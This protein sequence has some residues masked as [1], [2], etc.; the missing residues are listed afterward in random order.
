[1]REELVRT[2]LMTGATGFL[3]NFVLRDLLQRG[4]RVVAILRAPLADRRERLLGLLQE[5]GL[6]ARRCMENGQL[7]LIEGGLPDSLPEP[8]WGR[9][10]DILH[11]A[12]SLELFT[13]GDPQGDPYRTNVEGAMAMLQW[14]DRHE[15]K[16]VLAVSTAYTCGW[17]DGVIPEAF[18]DP[19]PQFQTDYE[20]S[21]WTAEMLFREWSRR[22]GRTLTVCRPSFLVGDSETGYTS[23]FAGFY[24]LARL[25]GVLKQ[26]YHDPNNGTRTYIPLRIPGNPED[27]QNVVPVDFVSRLIAEIVVR[28]Q[29]QG[30]IYHLTNPQP[31]TND[32]M[33]RCYEDYFGLH[34]GFFAPPDEVVGKCSPAESLL[35]DQYSLLT[36]RVVHTPQ[37]DTSHTQ[38]VMR[39]LGITFPALDKD[40]ILRLFDWAARRNWGRSSSN[41]RKL[42]PVRIAHPRRPHDVPSDSQTKK[43]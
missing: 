5:I 31:P 37:F 4:R 13:N 36:P 41:S 24:Q 35:W 15:V 6:D 23:Q 10:D 14:A 19:A 20:K 38:E 43:S 3:G 32:L 33:K 22:N 17:N 16:R 18:H 25:V 1:M 12:A 28:P 27:V 8:T 2:T 40:R 30:R 7:I 21:K 9:T 39:D 26:Q 42:D 34:G 11:N 29:Y